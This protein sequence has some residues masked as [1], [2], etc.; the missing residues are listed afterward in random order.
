MRQLKIPVTLRVLPSV[1]AIGVA[2]AATEVRSFANY[3]ESLI[4][5]DAR[6]HGVDAALEPRVRA[7]RS[8]VRLPV[9]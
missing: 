1:H 2:R 4:V 7:G 3:I 8:S 5:R 9:R 6:N